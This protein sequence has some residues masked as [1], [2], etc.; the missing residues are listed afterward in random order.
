MKKIILVIMF[1]MV[2][3][4]SYSQEGIIPEDSLD[5]YSFFER[6]GLDSALKIYTYPNAVCL[7]YRKA[8]IAFIVDKIDFIKI[9]YDSVIT[10][11][12]HPNFISTYHDT[13][14]GK[15]GECYIMLN[16][17]QS[18]YCENN[19]LVL[20]GDHVSSWLRIFIDPKQQN[21]VATL[22][23]SDKADCIDVFCQFDKYSK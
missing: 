18:G 3:S 5:E 13:R 10:L 6:I 7:G 1:C 11:L 9:S 15:K 17:Y 21:V 19:Q 22:P 4:Y 23:I 16:Y 2:N 14:K 12:G 8:A 20:I